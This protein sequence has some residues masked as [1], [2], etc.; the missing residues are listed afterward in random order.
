MADRASSQW[1]RGRRR[2][3]RALAAGLAVVLAALVPSGSAEAQGARSS[4]RGDWT[5]AAEALYDSNIFRLSDSQRR[6]LESGSGSDRFTDMSGP[7]D[8]VLELGLSGQV[9]GRG[10]GSRRV[11]MGV[12]L[13]VDAYA[14]N[15]RLTHVS[16]ETF[17]THALSSR[18]ELTLELGWRPGEFRRNYLAGAETSGAPTYA[19]GVANRAQA[20]LEYD[21]ELRKGSDHD[22]DLELSVEGSKR[23]LNDFPWRDRTGLTGAAELQV[24][25]SRRIDAVLS[26]ARGRGSH[27]GVP[28]PYIDATFVRTASLNRDFDETELGAGLT[29]NLPRRTELL[30]GWE[31]RARDY[32]A[33]L[34]EDPV[35]GDRQ[36]DRDTF[37]GELRWDR[38]GPLEVRVGGSFRRQDTQRP[39]Q[40]DTADE[41]DY[42]QARMFLS[43]RYSR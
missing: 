37:E 14:S 27:D 31:R 43:L 9:R 19:A 18:D 33:A 39:A 1:P 26:F 4:W 32:A 16:L 15:T 8:L 41:E 38:K 2:A 30:L 35:Y 28:E 22:L 5:V 13:E 21:R 25:L 20:R 24:E 40:G 11:T 3:L 7:S 17:A 42:R 10:L 29:F 23:S 34:G 12:G 6:Q 36:D